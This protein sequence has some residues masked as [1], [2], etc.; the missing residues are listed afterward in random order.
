[1]LLVKQ[2]VACVCVC[3]EVFSCCAEANKTFF[4]LVCEPCYF[5]VC[6]IEKN[7][8]KTVPIKFKDGVLCCQSISRTDVLCAGVCGGAALPCFFFQDRW[9]FLH[10]TNQEHEWSFYSCL[11][12][13]DS[14]YFFSFTHRHLQGEQ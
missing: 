8:I 6:T 1:M 3:R 10:I 14:C 13:H 7:P 4:S 11:S 2:T 5:T 12:K 9:V